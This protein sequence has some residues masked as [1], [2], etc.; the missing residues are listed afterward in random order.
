MNIYKRK[1]RN[2]KAIKQKII[3]NNKKKLIKYHS[4]KKIL[5]KK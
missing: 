1:M 3:Y 4:P 5:M 2:L